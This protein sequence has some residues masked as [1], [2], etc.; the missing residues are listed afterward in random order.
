MRFSSFLFVLTG[1]ASFTFGTNDIALKDVKYFDLSVSKT[2]ENTES[3]DCDGLYD[4]KILELYNSAKNE[5]EL[6]LLEN[7]Q[8]YYFNKLG[9]NMGN[10]TKGSCGFVATGMLLSFWDTYWDDNIISENFDATTE[11][12]DGY[13]DLYAESPGVIRE[14][15]RISDVEDNETYDQYIHDYADNYFH[16]KLID[17]FDRHIS[18]REPGDYGMGY[19]DYINL[20]NYYAY[21]YLG[22][23][24]EE[25]EIIYSDVDV[26]NKT[27]DL[28]KDGIPVKLSIG[29]HAVVAYDY[30]EKT[31]NIYC[32]FGWGPNT[33]HVTIEQMGYKDYKNLVAF[34]F[35]DD[36]HDHHSNNY[37]YINE[38]G[39]NDTLCSCWACIPKEV[40]IT[41]GNYLDE[42]PTYKWDSLIHE[43]WHRNL[44]LHFT[45]NILDNN[46]HEVFKDSNVF[47]P[48]Y[49]LSKSQWNTAIS[50]PGNSY[51]IYIG[52][53]SPVD[54]YWDDFYCI[55]EFIEPKDYADKAQI[56]PSDWN[57]EERYWFANEGENGNEYR[58]TNIAIKNLNITSHRLRCGYIE[59]QYVNLSPRREGA[60]E[61]YLRLTWDK[62]VYSYMFGASYWSS[63]ENLDGEAV[64]RVMDR[65]RVWQ[66]VSSSDFNLKTLGLS[67]TRSNIKRFVGKHSEGIYGLEFY[68]T[69]SATGDRNKG[70]ICIDDIVLNTD[71]YDLDFI[72]TS[73]SSIG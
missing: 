70:R 20:F 7:Y 51:Y 67:T 50:V 27:I 28:I 25:V 33:S 2:K 26:R 58:E 32:N 69:A 21:D 38:Y 19:Q 47:D 9:S 12:E 52:F 15:S 24:T 46:R 44:S 11:L 68:C 45:F 56:K 42:T 62:P 10:N 71:P 57:F 30:D 1:L 17:L 31:D 5:E 53:E 23:T 61:A 64:V 66:S 29:G 18:H 14:P 73:Y 22:Y 48:T 39:E 36:H 72:S 41:S 3:K 55:T 8:T 34:N 35:K 43:K 4:S 13:I 40:I 63:S 60:G 65:N 49:T 16:F 54:P 37:T 59:E 6:F